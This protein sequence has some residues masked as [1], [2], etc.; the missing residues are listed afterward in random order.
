MSLV[1]IK[2]LC[3]LGR[4]SPQILHQQMNS[5]SMLDD[6]PLQLALSSV[7]TVLTAAD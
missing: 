4:L 7:T 1:V 5:W 6:G 3:H 2:A